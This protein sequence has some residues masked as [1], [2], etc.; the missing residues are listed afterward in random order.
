MVGLWTKND[1]LSA[2]P[3]SFVLFSPLKMTAAEGEDEMQDG[4]CRD[5]EIAC[6]LFVWPIHARGKK[7]ET[8]G[9]YQRTSVGHRK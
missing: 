8:N 1:L 5:V 9:E 2:P 4:T 7:V 3:L 6:A